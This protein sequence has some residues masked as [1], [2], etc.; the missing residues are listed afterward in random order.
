VVV[1]VL[2]LLNNKMYNSLYGKKLSQAE[3]RLT[4]IIV[5]EESRA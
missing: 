1:L 3:Q 4:E 2:L 5:F